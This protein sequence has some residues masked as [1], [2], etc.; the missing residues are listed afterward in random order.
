[1]DH[2]QEIFNQQQNHFH[3]FL[4]YQPVNERIVKLKKL[5]KWIITHQQEIRDALYNDL[6]KPQ[7]EANITDIKFSLTELDHA[8]K[9]LRKW[10]KPERAKT[11]LFMIGTRSKI[12]CEPKGVVLIIA[13]WNFPFMLVVSPLVSAIAAG[14]CVIVKPSELSNHTSGIICKMIEDLFPPDE[15]AVF[16]GDEKTGQK[17][18]ELPFDHIF[19]TGS[20]RVGKIV[21]QAAAQRLTSVTLELGGQNPV[22]V[23]ESARVKEAAERIT[24][25]KFFNAGQSCVAPNTV[26]VHKSISEKLLDEIKKQIFQNYPEGYDHPDYTYIINDFHYYRLQNLVTD[27]LDKGAKTIVNENKSNDKKIF[28][29]VVLTGI[30][31]DAK[32]NNEEIFGPVLIVVSY[33]NI[34]EIIKILSGRPKPLALYIFSQQR[35]KINYILKNIASGTTV[36]NDTSIQFL[37]QELPFGGI[38]GSGIGRTHGYYGFLDFS[39]RRAVLKQK[40]GFTGFKLLNPPYSGKT[41]KI[42]KYVMRYF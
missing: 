5:K 39:N 28:A 21:M 11:P 20:P 41:D 10:T 31:D 35:S 25:G 9:N 42:V 34:D 7:T 6:H 22:I 1:M 19:F 37:Q 15:I 36:I 40:N 8:C 16:T 29:P 17:L 33:E 18:L 2:F 27:A 14:N 13:P 38:N 23:D 26:Y 24:L 32:I 12:I 30:S 4:R 3:N